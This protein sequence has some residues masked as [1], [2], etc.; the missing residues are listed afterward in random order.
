MGATNDRFVKVPKTGRKAFHGTYLGCKYK[1][2]VHN[3]LKPNRHCRGQRHA[4]H[5]PGLVPGHAQ[6]HAQ[7]LAQGLAQGHA[8]CFAPNFAPNYASKYVPNAGPVL[9][10]ICFRTCALSR[11]PLCAG[12]PGGRGVLRQTLRLPCQS[13]G[14]AFA[15]FAVMVILFEGAKIQNPATV[16]RRGFLRRF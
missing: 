14:S 9:R 10:P 2:N 7:G 13:P 4:G 1:S 3:G 16:F 6:G 11:V 5:A 12:L 15:V 8:Y